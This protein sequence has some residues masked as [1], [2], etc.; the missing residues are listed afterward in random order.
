M[1]V[2]L[3]GRGMDIDYVLCP[4]CRDVH[5]HA[6]HLSFK[7]M[8]AKEVW[9]RIDVSMDIGVLVFLDVKDMAHWIDSRPIADIER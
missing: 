4:V 2:N 1:R 6:T 5:E 7:Y 3:D 8:L 9:N